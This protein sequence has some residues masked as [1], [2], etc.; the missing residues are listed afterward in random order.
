MEPA[1]GTDFLTTEFQN[2]V[3]VG[4]LSEW[5]SDIHESDMFVAVGMSVTYGIPIR[6]S[7]RME[8]GVALAF[9]RAIPKEGILAGIDEDS[10]AD[11]TLFV[12]RYEQFGMTTVHHAAE[13]L[14]CGD[15]TSGLQPMVV[16]EQFG[17]LAE[18]IFC[19]DRFGVDAAGCCGVDAFQ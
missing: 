15:E 11:D 7:I 10:T 9:C 14:I 3:S 19:F 5:Q 13:Q 2:E 1:V 8:W 16:V 6:H 18:L 4:I 12:F 17:E